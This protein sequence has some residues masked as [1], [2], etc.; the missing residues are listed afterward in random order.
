M[1][2]AIQKIFAFLKSYWYI[3]VAAVAAIVVYL[4]TRDSKVVDWK[5][6]LKDA[7][8]AHDQEVKAIEKADK[9]KIEAINRANNRMQQAQ[10]QLKTEL[11]R[12]SRELDEKKAKRVQKIIK[13]LKDDPHALANEL[14][15]ETGVRVIIVE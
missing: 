6:V 1:S 8:Q 5:K 9:E 2:V 12:N 11:D 14:E 15:K 4:L 10:E 13:D 7:N 3:P